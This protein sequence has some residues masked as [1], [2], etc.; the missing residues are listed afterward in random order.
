[1]PPY[2]AFWAC[3]LFVI[4]LLYQDRSRN[5]NISASLW[6]PLTWLLIVASRLPSQW[7][8]ASGWQRD[9]YVDGN[10]LDRAIYLTLLLAGV[11]VLVS[12]STRWVELIKQN[13]ALTLLAL[14]GLCSVLWSDFPFVAFK[15]WIRDLGAYLMLVVVLSEARPL[16]AVGTLFRRLC[17]ILIPYSVLLIRYYAYFGRSYSHWTG[18]VS[19]TG[20]TNNKN[21]L[22]IL[23]LVSGLIFF[24]DI[25][26][27]WSNR[28]DRET[29]LILVLDLVMCLMT[30]YLLWLARSSTS[31]LCLFIGVV[32]MCMSRIPT[33]VANPARIRRLV[34][35]IAG[36]YLATD[37]IFDFK[38]L[39]TG[40]LGRDATFTGR[41]QLWEY[42]INNSENWLLGA[43]YESF[44]LGPRLARIWS[45]FTFGPNQAHNGYIELYLNLGMVGV[46]ALVLVLFASYRKISRAMDASEDLA[47]LSFSLWT[48]L[49]LYN[50]TEAAFK[51][52][53]LWLAFLL[54]AITVP[55]PAQL[56]ARTPA[57]RRLQPTASRFYRSGRITPKTQN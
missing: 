44:W 16:E 4:F 21:S 57:F 8:G 3:T 41:I 43:G 18:D 26:K 31:S 50:I 42:L 14:L 15:R 39:V 11:S 25:L 49:L 24:W 40:M 13:L 9:A 22:G 45:V 27:R 54:G 17:Y 28:S 34:I 35:G 2:I 6:I 7:M 19:Y 20:V 55:K 47:F 12:R 1:M 38:R 37:W 30:L 53:L 51:V 33:M 36:L 5:P 48:A 10:P 52:H 29:R 23:C 46:C 32:I 56:L